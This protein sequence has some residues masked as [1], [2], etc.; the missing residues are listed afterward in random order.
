[1]SQFHYALKSAE[2]E[3][4]TQLYRYETHS[5]QAGFRD[6]AEFGVA[7]PNMMFMYFEYEGNP[8]DG[9]FVNPLD[10]VPVLRTDRKY[11]LDYEMITLHVDELI[12]QMH[13]DPRKPLEHRLFTRV[14]VDIGGQRDWM[15]WIV[16]SAIDVWL[17]QN[18]E[19][20]DKKLQ[21]FV[22][23]SVPTSVLRDQE[24]IVVEHGSV[25]LGQGLWGHRKRG[26]FEQFWGYLTHAFKSP[27]LGAIGIPALVGQA[28][29]FVNKILDDYQKE[30]ELRTLWQTRKLDFRIAPDGDGTF[31]MKPGVWVIIDTNYVQQHPDLGGHRVDFKFQTF[32]IL[33]SAEKPIPVPY[34]VSR[35]GLKEKT[36]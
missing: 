22:Q 13:L 29:E 9:R 6:L 32:E 17:E 4:V 26:F 15:D 34:L 5:V 2:T 8:A 1:M 19:G 12:D 18:R 33:D 3:L 35:I 31:R 24:A 27:L 25:L 28:F 21:A 10:V 14:P 11:E 20:R 30:A 36:G 7:A 23:G 16:T